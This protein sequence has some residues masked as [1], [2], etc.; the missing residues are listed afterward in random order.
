MLGGALLV[1][2]DNPNLFFELELVGGAFLYLGFIYSD[3][4]IKAKAASVLD[5]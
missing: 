2:F 3:R 4:Y 1:L 5:N